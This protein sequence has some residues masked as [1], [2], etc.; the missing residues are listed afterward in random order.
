ME[1]SDWS[2]TRTAFQA[3]FVVGDPLHV[4]WDALLVGDTLLK[5]RDR[6]FP[7]K[8]EHQLTA[9]HHLNL[10]SVRPVSYTHLSCRRR[11]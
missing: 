6:V 11:G 7:L 5:V 1:C 3:A 2:V 10:D 8:V 9:V 4:R